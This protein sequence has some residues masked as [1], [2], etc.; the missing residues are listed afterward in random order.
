MR[1]SCSERKADTYPASLLQG[2]KMPQGGRDR[3][4]KGRQRK[5][6]KIRKEKEGTERERRGRERERAAE[7]I[8]KVSTRKPSQDSHSATG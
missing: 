3:E 4:R 2:D 7:L 8:V 6:S 5:G 1:Q